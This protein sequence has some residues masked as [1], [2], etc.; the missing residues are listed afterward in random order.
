MLNKTGVIWLVIIILCSLRA[1]KLYLSSTK[2]L[3]PE[4]Y[5]NWI[6]A[7]KRLLQQQQQQQPI[8]DIY[9]NSDRNDSITLGTEP[10]N[11]FYFIHVTDLHLSR[12]RPKG[13]TYHFL[14]F[15]QSILPVVR[16][17]F[18]VVTGDL[19]DA[20]DSKRITSQQ[21]LDEWKVYQKA[22]QEKV[23]EDMG[24]Y[25]IRGNHDCFDLPSWKSRI[26]YYRTHGKSAGLVEQGKGIYSWQVNQPMGNY[27]FVAID[28]CP[29][30][31]PSR[32]L[33]FFGYLTSK[34]MDQLERALI[35]KK[36]FNHTFLFSH[37]PT[38]TMVFGTSKTGK[39]F[40]DLAYH[41]SVY[42]CGHLHKLIAGIGDVLK[43]YDPISKSLELELGDLKEHALYRIVA[44][45][46]DLISFVDLQLPLD[47]IPKKG[48]VNAIGLVQPFDDTSNNIIWPQL[49]QPHQPSILVTNPKD[50]RFAIPSKEPLERIRASTNIRFLVFS[51]QPPEE[52]KVQVF[53]NDEP[54]D[55]E[56][57][58]AGDNLWTVPWNPAN[59]SDKKTHQL[60]IQVTAL[61]REGQQ[62]P[63]SISETIFRLDGHRVKIKGG[64][65]EFI[66][67]SKM[68][69]V[70]Q[71]ITFFAIFKMF[72]L[73]LIPKLFTIPSAPT[74]QQHQL[75]LRIH[76]I[77][78]LPIP[79]FY[80]NLKKTILIW[81]LRFVNF[82]C[83]QPI[84]WHATLIYLLALLTLPWFRAKFI[85]SG[86]SEEERYGTFYLWGMMFGQEWIPIGD[87]WMLAAEQVVFDVLVFFLILAWR[88]TGVVDYQC[89][90]ATLLR[91][92]EP[93]FD[94]NAT[95][96]VTAAGDSLQQE[97]L[98]DETTTTSLT[99]TNRRL[100]NRTPRR[101]RRPWNEMPLSKGLPL[102][103]WLWR[104]SEL[105]ALASFYGGIWPTL[106]LNMNVY[107]M[108]FIGYQLGCGKHG[109]LVSTASSLSRRHVQKRR[110]GE[111]SNS[112]FVS[113][114]IVE[115]CPGCQKSYYYTMLSEKLNH[116]QPDDGKFNPNAIY[117]NS[118]S[119]SDSQIAPLHSG[120][121]SSVDDL[122]LTQEEEQLTHGQK[123]GDVSM[124]Q[125]NLSTHTSRHYSGS[126]SSGS[127]TPFDGLPSIK[128]RKRISKF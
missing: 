20:K 43:S 31:G 60:R 5:S 50:A 48:P 98:V 49:V 114:I 57:V 99:S 59:L 100:A 96:T 92:Q 119:D 65:G 86:D 45:D 56:A 26:N 1:C 24:W 58:Y 44:I 12:F 25:D 126:S 13:H 124:V 118:Q 116:H 105:M 76:A 117:G 39:T 102:L 83:E 41:Y 55:K 78:L 38:T 123:V 115:G 54:H 9:A 67:K 63:P 16:P 121:A 3:R 10:N 104:A 112:D 51:I 37:Y 11:L 91:Q 107:W 6:S 81:S 46:H 32:P 30:K 85:P 72:L 127:S 68:I 90:G 75:L 108:F 61:P 22:I 7:K 84:V 52:L 27:Q 88:E 73:L 18:V 17:K 122:T 103:Y 53:I 2:E 34:T 97:Y 109:I 8:A 21:Y 23:P 77:E 62:L 14:H 101:C 89:P 15:I 82:A 33:N 42:F 94:A 47:K 70:L 69:T 125:S 113:S 40:K 66:I 87:T 93:V 111:N 128:S 64:S 29:K 74:K 36:H 95:N 19:T 35:S 106:I 110:R 4:E 120:C 28:A 71:C 79:S 80:S